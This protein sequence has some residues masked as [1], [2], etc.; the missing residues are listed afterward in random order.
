MLRDERKRLFS[1]EGQREISSRRESESTTIPPHSTP[2]N[3]NNGYFAA[4]EQRSFVFQPNLG[5]RKNEPELEIPLLHYD[6]LRW[7]K[8]YSRNVEMRQTNPNRVLT[9]A[10]KTRWSLHPAKYRDLKRKEKKETLVLI[11]LREEENQKRTMKQ[12]QVSPLASKVIDK[13]TIMQN[14]IKKQKMIKDSY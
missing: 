11:K 14:R 2:K 5:N 13:E 9:T 1:A 7:S 8:N 3:E 6:Q 10:T 12:N 4:I